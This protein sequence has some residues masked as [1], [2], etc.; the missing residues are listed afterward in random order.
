MTAVGAVVPVYPTWA[1]FWRVPRWSGKWR[2]WFP[3]NAPHGTWTFSGRVALYHGLP[4]LKLPAGSTILVPAYHQGVEIDT[5]LAAGHRL[6]YYRITDTLEIDF[7]HLAQQVDRS[8]SALYVIHYFGFGQPLEP[9]QTFCQ[10]HRLR[11]IEDCALSLFSKVDGTWLGSVGDLALYSVYKMLPIPHGGFLVTKKSHRARPAPAPL[12]STLIQS[13]DL[14]HSG[15]HA[16][17]S[18]WRVER[19]LTKASAWMKRAVRWD[20]SGTISSGGAQWDPR[21][22]EYGASSWSTWLMR[23][24]DPAEVV[25]RRR[26]N[27]GQMAWRLMGR[28]PTPFTELEPGVCPLFFPVMV[29]D[30]PRFQRQLEDLGVQ[31]VNLWDASHPT[32][33][34]DLAE[35]VSGWRRQCLELPIHQELSPGD[36]DRVADAVL[37]VLARHD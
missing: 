4:S 7:E 1:Q 29:P 10:S 26:R 13:L 31:T 21:L 36:V 20:R 22:L 33:P 6:R 18:W 24:M 14:L 12:S 34:P 15:L 32:C 19:R 37:T 11:L 17:P 35:E 30:K 28:L 27:F 23:L 8:V 2:D 5:L 25:A 3:F 9:I 16:S